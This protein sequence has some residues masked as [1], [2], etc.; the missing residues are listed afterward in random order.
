MKLKLL[1]AVCFLLVFNKISAQQLSYNFINYTVDNGLINNIIYDIRVDS[2]NFAWIATSRGLQRFD[3]QDFTTFSH[4][5][6]DSTTIVDNHINSICIDK[7][8]NL[9]LGTSGFGLEFYDRKKQIFQHS[10]NISTNHRFI[11]RG[12]SIVELDNGNIL[13][14]SFYAL[15]IFNPIDRKIERILD[16]K[17]DF[18]I[19]SGNNAYTVWQDSLIKIDLTSL[20]ITYHINNKNID[21]PQINDICSDSKGRSG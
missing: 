13:Y 11:D 7:N 4:S 10:Q 6:A 9:W 16:L 3:G 14:K 17:T 1:V 12:K 19:K 5:P 21:L 15:E 20:K 18:L 2:M 8:N